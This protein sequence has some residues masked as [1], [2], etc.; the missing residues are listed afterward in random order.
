MLSDHRKRITASRRRRAARTGCERRRAGRPAVLITVIIIV[1]ISIDILIRA[2]YLI[3]KELWEVCAYLRCIRRKLYK[4]CRKHAELHRNDDLLFAVDAKRYYQVG[5]DFS[6]SIHIEISS[7]TVRGKTSF[8]AYIAQLSKPWQECRIKYRRH[9][10]FKK[11]R[12]KQRRRRRRDIYVG[13]Y[14]EAD[15]A[16][17]IIYEYKIE[18][19][20]YMT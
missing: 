12:K 11:A 17:E 2:V 20:Y 3:R 6:V 5:R 13:C 16:P 15:L 18:R 9:A 10:H 1:S 14:R 7:E 4:S 19:N 8:A